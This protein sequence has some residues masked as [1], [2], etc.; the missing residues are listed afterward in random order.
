MSYWNASPVV[1][2]GAGK[3]ILHEFDAKFPVENNRYFPEVMQGSSGVRPTGSGTI[4]DSIKERLIFQQVLGQGSYGTVMKAEDTL[5]HQTFAVKMIR[6]TAVRGK[7]KYVIAERRVLQ[8]ASG[9]PFLVHAAFAIQTEMNILFGLKYVSCGDLFD[10]LDK[11]GRLDVTSS[12]FYAAELVC[13]IQ[14][15]HLKGV[16]HRDLKPENILITD[17]GH[18]KITDFDLALVNMHGG[19]TST[20]IAGTAG[21]I[22]P[23]MEAGKKFN[24]A[25]D[26][27]SFGVTK[28]M[29]TCECT[30]NPTLLRGISCSARDIIEKLLQKDPARRLGLHGD[31]RGHRFFRSI[32][33]D[34][35]ET[36]KMAPPYIPEPPNSHPA[37]QAAKL[38]E[39]EAKEASV[40]PPSDT[41]TKFPGFSFVNWKTC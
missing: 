8:L 31:I 29:L 9:T 30:Y 35:V 33:W 1:S 2:H 7:E 38:D 36:L 11:K 34:S 41:R 32:D 15:L 25:V 23:E 39:I 19:R 28:D 26:W 16:I 14:F 3:Y 37:F 13:G 40:S 24:T 10:L 21:Y 5:T 12:R 17:T 18:I 27:Y 22:A 4:S 6:K 20:S